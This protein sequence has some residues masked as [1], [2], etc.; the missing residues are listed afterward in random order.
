M[1]TPDPI[2]ELDLAIIGNKKTDHERFI[3]DLNNMQH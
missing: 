3:Q 2:E 1:K